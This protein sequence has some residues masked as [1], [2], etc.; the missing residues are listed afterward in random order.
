MRKNQTRLAGGSKVQTDFQFAAAGI[1]SDE[2][3]QEKYRA[4]LAE[5]YYTRKIYPLIDV[6]AD[7]IRRYYQQNIAQ[8]TIPESA[9]FRVI[10]IDDARSGG[11]EKARAKRRKIVTRAK[12]GEDFADLSGRFN[13]DPTL[14]NSKGAVG[15][16]GQ[17]PK[18]AYVVEPV[19][20]AVWK[21]HPGEITDPP[22]DTG[23]AFYIAKVESL[24]AGGTKPFSD[25]QV[26]ESISAKLERLQLDKLR[27]KHLEEL[28][29]NSIIVPVDGM[30]QVV[31]E[32]LA[33]K[34][35]QWAKAK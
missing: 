10:K 35:A 29:K 20:N 12:T 21:L 6:S 11:K 7:D 4:I 23:D 30:D 19:E 33:Q 2:A 8:Y 9:Q 17:M 31:M 18:G 22:I 16:N 26:Q 5:I 28:R 34:Y 32:M 15:E 24:Q 13:D 25:P 3:A 14:M 27:A 1:D